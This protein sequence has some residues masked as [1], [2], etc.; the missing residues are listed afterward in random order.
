MHP[1]RGIFVELKRNAPIDSA[2]RRKQKMT[3]KKKFNFDEVSNSVQCTTIRPAKNTDLNL[4][5]LLRIYREFLQIFNRITTK[6]N[7]EESSQV[8]VH[9]LV[10]EILF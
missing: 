1:A 5:N 3:C 4:R 6:R 7:Q 2:P 8:T 9:Q 10:W